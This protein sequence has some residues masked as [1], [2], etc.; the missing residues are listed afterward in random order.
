[1]N[2]D[3]MT[4]DQI[5]NLIKDC[6]KELVN[7]ERKQ[8]N[9]WREIAQRIENYIECYGKESISL[10]TYDNESFTIRDIFYHNPAIKLE[11]IKEE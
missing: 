11:K 9:E 1:M 6:K 3:N 8:E 4:N 5:L 7:R 2:F 10:T